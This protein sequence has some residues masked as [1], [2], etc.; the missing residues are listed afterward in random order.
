MTVDR[1]AGIRLS[2]RRSPE[3]PLAGRSLKMGDRLPHTGNE[4]GSQIGI[5]LRL[6]RRFLAVA[7]E[8]SFAKAA[9][10]LHVTQAILSRQIRKLEAELKVQLLVRQ[11]G[12][13]ELTNAGNTLSANSRNL[14]SLL[15]ETIHSVRTAAA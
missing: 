15:A 6:L 9:K 5:E 4:V 10:R 1:F 14:L 11:R 7:E 12:S 8:R 3:N 2:S 13:V